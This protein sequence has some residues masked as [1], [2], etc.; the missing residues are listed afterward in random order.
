MRKFLGFLSRV[1]P[2]Q[3][4]TKKDLMV[5]CRQFSIL[6]EAGIPIIKALRI[7]AGQKE[8]AAISEALSG[9]IERIEAGN[10]LSS[11]FAAN[12]HVFPPVMTN[13]VKSGEEGGTLPGVMNKLAAHFEREY[14]LQEKIKTSVTYPAF[15]LATSLL[16]ALFLL[17]QVLPSFKHIF[18]GLGMDMPLFTRCLVAIGEALKRNWLFI[19]FFAGLLLLAARHILPGIYRDSWL[20]KTP[21]AGSLYR[22]LTT[23]RFAGNLG[24]LLHSGVD[25]LTSIDL[26]AGVCPGNSYA[27]VLRDAKEAVRQGRSLTEPLEAS[28]LFPQTALEMI[29]VGE[30]TGMM[31]AMLLKIAAYYEAE[32]DYYVKR[33][34]SLVEP[35]LIL[36]LAFMIG[37]IAL[38]LI[39]P[40]TDIFYHIS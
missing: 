19:I 4:T 26:A 33:L 40:L 22:K 5:F 20:L 37:G 17:I 9:V 39:I 34:G 11:A 18:L 10:S 3:K 16:V 8:C 32:A 7:L 1:K 21:V 12:R 31:D 27:A 13:T 14:G 38:S 36:V 6:L 24:M 2:V 23:A 35:V 29:K 28:T 25:L 30:E 15:V